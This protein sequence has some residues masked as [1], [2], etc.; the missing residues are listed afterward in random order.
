[1]L[2]MGEADVRRALEVQALLVKGGHLCSSWASLLVAAVGERHGVTVLHCDGGFDAI[3]GV[4]G[5]A[6][7][8]TT[9]EP[10]R[11]T[12]AAEAHRELGGGHAVGN[13]VLFP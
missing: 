13:V 7:E 8:W 9:K 2:E 6:C 1:M 3:A 11:F 4:T 5:Q 12:E 10:V